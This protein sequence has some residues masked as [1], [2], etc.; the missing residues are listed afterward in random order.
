LPA[1]THFTGSINRQIY[2]RKATALLRDKQQVYK[3]KAT[4]LLRDK[5]RLSPESCSHR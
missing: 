3:R 4:A 1:A 5:Q 2:K